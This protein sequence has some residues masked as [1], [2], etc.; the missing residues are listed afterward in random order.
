MPPSRLW[1]FLTILIVA[2]PASLAAQQR[3]SLIAKET[4]VL[5][6]DR[7]G[8]GTAKLDGMWQF[9]LG[10]DPDSKLGWKDPELDDATGHN[11]W[12]AISADRPWGEQGHLRYGGFAWYRR[13]IRL[14]PCDGSGSGWSLL[15]ERVDDAYEVYWNGQFLGGL[16][17]LPPNRMTLSEHD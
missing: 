15:I 9:H 3:G 2:G 10:D 7:L 13:H 12:E 5:R 1:L 16:G 6:L 14:T 11:G 8:E 17:K 4:P